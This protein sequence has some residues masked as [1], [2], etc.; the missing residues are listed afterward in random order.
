MSKNS[1]IIVLKEDKGKGFVISDRAKDLDKCCI[2]LDSNQFT[3][4]DQGPTCYIE[5]NAQRTL[6]KV[7]STMP[8]NVY[9]KLYLSG[10]SPRKSYGTIKMNKHL[11]NNADDLPLRPII[12]NRRNSSIPDCKFS[13]IIVTIRYL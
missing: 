1:S 5:A 7:K 10:S 2:I 9:L 6:R 4:P 12:S 3:K 11:T 8:Q 13:Q